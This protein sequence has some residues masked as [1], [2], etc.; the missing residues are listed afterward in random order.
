MLSHNDLDT[1]AADATLGEFAEGDDVK[2]F[3]AL[4]EFVNIVHFE[5]VGEP[6]PFNDLVKNDVAAFL[7]V[8]K[9]EETP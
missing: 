9:T 6:W 7:A 8:I 4:Q 3:A 2:Y 5:T 1:I